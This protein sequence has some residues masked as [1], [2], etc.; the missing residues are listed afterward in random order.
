MI[1]S[2]ILLI[3]ITSISSWYLCSSWNYTADCP[4]LMVIWAAQ[5]STCVRHQYICVPLIHCDFAVYRSR[6]C[7]F[8]SLSIFKHFRLQPS[9]RKRTVASIRCH[10]LAGSS[11]VTLR[12]SS[13]SVRTIN[14]RKTII[15]C[16]AF[17]GQCLTRLVLEVRFHEI[18]THTTSS[19][20]NCIQSLTKSAAQNRHQIWIA[21][22]LGHV[23]LIFLPDDLKV[24]R[25]KVPWKHLEGCETRDW[26][27]TVGGGT[28][29]NLLSEWLWATVDS[30]RSY[31]VQD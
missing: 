19:V 25:S 16:L 26:L 7:L 24:C 10:Y 8:I 23:L 22:N 21:D 1:T 17:I 13:R 28:V 12:Y 30:N 4:F 27:P 20:L 11:A 6:M 29:I 14:W 5:E 9:H 2:I 31:C 3:I 18:I 15:F